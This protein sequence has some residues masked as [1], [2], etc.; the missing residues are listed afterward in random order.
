MLPGTL[1]P[2]IRVSSSSR[3]KV[4]HAGGYSL[5]DSLRTYGSH[6]GRQGVRRSPRPCQ[7]RAPGPSLLPLTQL[8]RTGSWAPAKLALFSRPTPPVMDGETEA[9]KEKGV[10]QN[11]RGRA[12][13]RTQASLCIRAPPSQGSLPQLKSGLLLCLVIGEQKGGE[14]R[15]GEERGEVSLGPGREL[16]APGNTRPPWD[17]QTAPPPSSVR[18]CS[19]KHPHAP[20]TFSPAP[21]PGTGIA[22]S[23][24]RHSQ[25]AA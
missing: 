22:A 9:R 1:T 2:S 11:D 6:A 3:R 17:L 14:G 24:D 10:V 12:W 16:E 20:R 15:G 21:T 18:G 8:S 13:T 4:P 7:G 25:G 5:S 19:P 23:P